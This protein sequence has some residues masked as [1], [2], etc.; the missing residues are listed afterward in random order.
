LVLRNG[1]TSE[2]NVAA[3]DQKAAKHPPNTIR[4]SMPDRF[5]YMAQNCIDT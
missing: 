4:V 5:A 1:F 2:S 3:G